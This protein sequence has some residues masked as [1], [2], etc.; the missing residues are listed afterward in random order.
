MSNDEIELYEGDELS[1]FERFVILSDI[2]VTNQSN[3]KIEV[4]FYL[5]FFYLQLISGFFSPQI[6]ILK[7]NNSI[8]KFLSY[9]E[10]ITRLKN[11]FK[12]NFS[13]YKI[14]SYFLFIFFN[15]SGIYFIYLIKKTNKKS[16][17]DFQK[18][19]FIYIFKFFIY[20]AYNMILDLSIVNFCF[21]GNKN[22]IILEASCSLKDDVFTSI[23]YIYSFL[24]ST[25]MIFIVQIFN[26]DSFYLSTSYFSKANCSYDFIMI[27]H[28]IIYSFILNQTYLSKYIFLI[29]NLISSIFFFQ[30]FFY[31][32]LF[33]EK[34][35]FIFSGLFHLLYIWVSIIFLLFYIFPIDNIG[36]VFIYSSLLVIFAGYKVSYNLDYK[37]IYKTPFYKI[38][39]HY[40]V[41]YFIK[42]L[43]RIINT[44]DEDEE[45]KTL[46]MG[47]LEIH[48]IECDNPSCLAKSNK[49]IY[50]PKTDRWSKDEKD[51]INNKI[52]LNS[53]VVT[54]LNFWIAENIPFPD[55][56]LT[57]SFYNLTVIEN[58]CQSLYL[59]K[60][61]QRL[62]LNFHE[63]FGFERLK[64]KIR[65]YLIQ[66]LKG[67][68]KPVHNLSE[69]NF[70]LY[71]KYD[72]LSKQFIQEITNDIN[73]S[74]LFWNNLKNNENSINY[75]DFFKLTEKIRFSKLKITKLFNEL[76]II[77]NGAND[78]F[79]L[80]S[81]Y[82]ETVNNDFITK[83]KLELI[84]KKH[85]RVTL[86]L[87]KINYFSILFGKDTGIIIGSGDKGHEGKILVINKAISDL[88]GYSK[89]ELKGKIC[90]IIMPKNLAK[91]H[92]SFIKNFFSVGKKNILGKK[93]F[94]GFGKDKDNNIIMIKLSVNLFPI[95]NNSVLFVV[96]LKKDKNE[97]LILIDNYFNIQGMSSHLM[98]KL[99][100]ENKQL[101]KYYDIPFYAIC[102]QF[103]GLYKNMIVIKNKKLIS[104]ASS[105]TKRGINEIKRTISGIVKKV[106]DRRKTNTN[107][108]NLDNIFSSTNRE[109]NQNNNNNN[110]NNNDN[111][112]NNNENP[113]TNQNKLNP[114]NN[115]NYY[116]EIKSPQIHGASSFFRKSVQ[117]E[118]S[119][120]NLILEDISNLKP[121]KQLLDTNENIELESEIQIPNFILN[122][123]TNILNKQESFID[124]DSISEDINEDNSFDESDFLKKDDIKPKKTKE[125]NNKKK[126]NF[127]IFTHSHHNSVFMNN[128]YL[129]LKNKNDKSEEEI[130]FLYKIYL[131]KLYFLKEEFSKLKEYVNKCI[132]DYSSRI[133]YNLL[134]EKINLGKD[135]FTY[136]VRVSENKDI[137]DIIED[138][139]EEED[140]LINNNNNTITKQLEKK[141][142]EIK[143]IKKL[144]SE[145]L[146]KLYFTFPEERN[147]L[148]ALYTIFIQLSTNDIKF[149]ENL[150]K[151]KEDIMRHS[152]VHGELKEDIVMDD[153]N[154]SQT[155]SN[156]NEDLSKKNRIEEIRNNALKNIKNYKM[157]KYYKSLLFVIISCFGAFLPIIINYFDSLCKNLLEVTNINNKL[158]QTTNWIIFLLNSLISF[159]TIFAIN[160]LKIENFTYNLYLDTLEEYVYT[161]QHYS[162]EWIELIITNFSLIEKAIATFTKES[163]DI[164]WEKE[165]VLNLNQTY[166]SREPYP[167]ALLQILS[168][169]NN[170]LHDEIY[171]NIILGNT[172]INDY[173]QKFIYYRAHTCINNAFRVFL[174]SNLEKIKTLPSIL[175][176]L[177]NNS[178]NN[179][180]YVNI[181]CSLIVF[182]IVIIYVFI[183]YKTNK[184]IDEGFEKIST[185]KIAKINETIKKLD[186]FNNS[187]KK[188]I[189]MNFEDN[190]YF[191][192][193]T[194]NQYEFTTT[195]DRK[196]NILMQYS[197]TNK[198]QNE[199]NIFDELKKD[200][201]TNNNLLKIK[202]EK[203][204]K[205]Q[206]FQY[207]YIQPLIL[208]FICGEFILTTLLISKLIVNSSNEIINVQTFIYE[209]VLSSSTA[210]LDL[211]YSLTYYPIE[212]DIPYLKVSSNFSLTKVMNSITKFDDIL[213]LYNNMQ[214]NIC[215]AT[216]NSETQKDKYQLCL[217]DPKV[218]VVNNT[219]SIFKLIDRKVE[220]LM[221]LKNFYISENP[222]YD[223]KLL[224][225]SI[226]IQQC[227]YLFY[228][229]II[230]FIDN[231]S[232][233]TLNTQKKKLNN[234]RKIAI[235]LYVLIIIEIIIFTIYILMFFL[236]KII[237]FLSV[238]RCIF[239]I[240]P[241]N[242]IYSTPELSSWIENNFNS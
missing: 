134:F 65:N 152:I 219:N 73:F 10:K 180:I 131:Y 48:K 196:T 172:L 126:S 32:H 154:S 111:N 183:L 82:V 208:A 216:F 19:I 33:H 118:T 41:L 241:I 90:S 149:K 51:L 91:I 16:F 67:S 159:D 5:C 223:T 127:N 124:F 86:D 25:I 156:F 104:S 171:I 138:E 220:T 40:Y 85:D 189:E 18:K 224:Y 64:I 170:L 234:N 60:K 53:F 184:N 81:L 46:L 207:S 34:S 59:L 36:L 11:L 103:I 114:N 153:E 80:Y 54:L 158:Y 233:T 142:N 31:V 155:S 23:C 198:N 145:N 75:N 211:K 110:N 120:K 79:E 209:L 107:S 193:K 141:N 242:V 174:P 237:Y 218:Q 9:I 203:T 66:G 43:V 197:K 236:N 47:I 93:D 55:I 123:R 121:P 112:N 37:L 24:Y 44:I 102:P 99:N 68:N 146:K 213:T 2:F 235:C 84:K 70:S 204:K 72:E 178:L 192:I 21:K 63:F 168:N 176:E 143:Q 96:M 195:L 77:Y 137:E 166:N 238:E 57:L 8:D 128:D 191:D 200:N 179:I 167:L 164:F 76:F 210:F 30:Y 13:Q 140:D 15:V 163:R 108:F 3:S 97:D 125:E 188:F 58:I 28:E 215:E 160:L 148:I 221:E 115:L 109:S 231:I 61:I 1:Y 133:K 229:Y 7:M 38:K 177:N 105:I 71:F 225:S 157:L 129:R 83:R 144:K 92:S 35:V 162:L 169:A 20:I 122:Y 240:I 239:K 222:N 45:R 56:L 227:E 173:Q 194:L 42:E 147:G 181:F 62:K 26:N 151:S 136:Y 49:K 199:Q 95:L 202:I 212:H 228:N 217:N 185:I 12:H 89:E 87:I 190:H 117:H 201:N 69:L 14:I 132:S 139:N 100:I 94:R 22:N 150:T 74:I 98:A 29:Y 6:G 186:E 135:D 113:N 119:E 50:N 161:I 230:F 206:L 214:I 205:L 78:I 106:I 101:F 175:Q 130:A 165:E 88:F 232:S 17:F 4:F 226:E 182:I 187:L 39:N 52:F 116:P 27:I